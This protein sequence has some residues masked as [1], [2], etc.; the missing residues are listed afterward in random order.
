MK[1]HSQENEELSREWLATHEEG[2]FT[3][4]KI[5]NCGCRNCNILCFTEE[6]YR[7]PNPSFRIWPYYLNCIQAK[8]MRLCCQCYQHYGGYCDVKWAKCESC[9]HIFL[10]SQVTSTYQ[11]FVTDCHAKQTINIS[12]FT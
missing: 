12:P 3:V 4:D 1:C 11:L 2:L 10:R 5:N 8:R 9:I 7:I 6:L